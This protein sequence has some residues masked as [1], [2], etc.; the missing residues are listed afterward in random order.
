[1]TAL[2]RRQPL[3]LL[4][5]VSLLLLVPVSAGAQTEKKVEQAEERRRAAYAELVEANEELEAAIEELEVIRGKIY[6]LNWRIDLLGTRITEYDGEVVGLEDDARDLVLEAYTSGGR[7]MI[8]AAFSAG[9]IQDLLT[10][11]VLLERATS[12]EL[13]ALDR[14]SAVSREMDRLTVEL[15][16]KTN[17]IEVLEQQQAEVVEK[18]NVLQ[19]NAQKLFNH[20][21]A[22]YRIAVKRYKEAVA[23]EAARKA[24]LRRGGAAGLPLA[25]TPGVVCPV[26]GGASFIDSWGYPRSGGRTHKG[27]DMYRGHRAKLAA[28][29]SGTVRVSSH[30]L[31]GKQVYLYADNGI[32]YYYAHLSGWA[33]GLSTGQRVAKGQLVGYMGDS[34]NARGTTHLH[35]GMGPTGGGLVNPYPTF[36]RVC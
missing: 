3:T 20:T 12:L 32:F 8:T 34:G 18:L 21:D 22:D 27:T 28:V 7:D 9:S 29:D 15:D 5:I 13:V 31:G 10:S 33:P 14:L 30:Y 6:N 36:R 4:I 1:M 25:T 23:R 26:A 19:E 16:Q 17:E 11:Q 2:R 24:A 35:F